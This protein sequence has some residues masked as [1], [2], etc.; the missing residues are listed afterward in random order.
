MTTEAASNDVFNKGSSRFAAL[1]RFST[2]TFFFDH[3]CD[4]VDV[5]RVS[6]ASLE[7][8]LLAFLNGDWLTKP[9]DF[10]LSVAQPRG[11]VGDFMGNTTGFDATS[12][13]ERKGETIFPAG[14]VCD[15]FL[16]LRDFFRGGDNTLV[17]AVVPRGDGEADLPCAVDFWGDETRVDT[18]VPRGDGEADLRCEVDFWGDDTRVDTV[19]PRGDGEAD[20]RCTVDFWGDD[21]RV[22]TSDPLG[23]GEA[24]LCCV[25]DLS[26]EGDLCDV[27][28]LC[29][30]EARLGVVDPC[31]EADL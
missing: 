30:V 13:V 5:S 11:L 28:D 25:G 27:L 31:S 18:V 9:L 12:S 29:G 1:S 24:D 14:F 7:W 23:D 6:V 22:D 8:L 15:I 3:E 21:T 19:D 16:G 17:D 4:D 20:L 26:G 10:N 2:L